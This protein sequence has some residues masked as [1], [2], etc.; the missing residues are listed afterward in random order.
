VKLRVTDNKGATGTKTIAF[1][2][3]AKPVALLTADRAVPNVGDVV[4]LPVRR[5]AP[6]AELLA[7]GPHERLVLTLT[8]VVKNP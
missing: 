8:H 4:D 1:R 3:R 6:A 5:P 7:G 2:V